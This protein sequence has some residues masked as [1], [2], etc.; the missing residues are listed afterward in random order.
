MGTG[1]SGLVEVVVVSGWALSVVAAI[2]PAGAKACVVRAVVWS[3][4]RA[5][6]G[7]AAV[8]STGA[9]RAANRVSVRVIVVSCRRGVRLWKNAWAEFVPFLSFD[10]AI[11]TVICSTNAIECV[12]ARIRKAVRAR[13]P[14][15]TEAAA[16]KCVSMAPMSL[17]PT[18]KG[19]KRWTMRWKAPLDAFQTAFEGRLTPADN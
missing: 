6:A 8:P 9:R 12:N 14:F 18:G 3:A 11:R 15:P 17:D 1:L 10:V 5:V 19:R 7:V 2:S 4:E 13:V 16:V